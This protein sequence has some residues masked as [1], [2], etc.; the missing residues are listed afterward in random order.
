MNSRFRGNPRHLGRGAVA[1][2][3]AANVWETVQFSNLI[4]QTLY[5]R[6]GQKTVFKMYLHGNHIIRTEGID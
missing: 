1:A 2:N 3:V 5:I 6:F 4:T